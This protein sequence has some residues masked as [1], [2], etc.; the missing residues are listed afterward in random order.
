MFQDADI[1]GVL[2]IADFKKPY[3][4][5]REGNSYFKPQEPDT[6]VVES[7]GFAIKQGYLEGSNVNII[8]NMVDMISAYRNF[9]A[10]QKAETSQDETLQKA[11]N[12]VGRIS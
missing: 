6:A 1:K 5:L 12:D 4:L 2:R 10:D 8:K 3:K 11:I 9:E 7:Q